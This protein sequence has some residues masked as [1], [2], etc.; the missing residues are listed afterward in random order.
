VDD[1]DLERLLAVLLDQRPHGGLDAVLVVAG[2]HHGGDDRRVPVDGRGGCASSRREHRRGRAARRRLAGSR[3][4]LEPQA[5]GEP[6]RAR[7]RRR[8]HRVVARLLGHP[9]ATAIRE[10]PEGDGT[11]LGGQPVGQPGKRVGGEELPQPLGVIGS[12]PLIHIEPQQPLRV[13]LGRG[14][15]QPIERVRAV[16]WR[17][18]GRRLVLEQHADQGLVPE[19]LHG[20]VGAAFVEGQDTIGDRP[21]GIEPRRQRHGVVPCDHQAEEPGLRTRDRHRRIRASCPGNAFTAA[22]TCARTSG[23]IA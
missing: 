4:P 19:H 16:V 7:D 21:D 8:D 23:S 10:Q 12:D 18:R 14:V 6:A 20:P 9:V 2:D 5:G 3:E 13:Q 17:S 15:E 22:A 11:S 1:D